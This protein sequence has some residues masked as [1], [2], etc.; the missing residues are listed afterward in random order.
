MYVYGYVYG[1]SRRDTVIQSVCTCVRARGRE[2]IVDRDQNREHE[3]AQ[4]GHGWSVRS[5]FQ[6]TP[7][8]SQHGSPP[9]LPSSRPFSLS[10]IISYSIFTSFSAGFTAGIAR[11]LSRLTHCLSIYPPLT[12]TCPVCHPLS[13]R[14][15]FCHRSSH[16]SIHLACSSTRA[17][18]QNY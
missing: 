6:T 13:L 8:P 17:P 10:P 3:R 1:C 15:S 4:I 11:S 5:P 18:F 9:I 2:R 14:F 7:S 16:L 12:P